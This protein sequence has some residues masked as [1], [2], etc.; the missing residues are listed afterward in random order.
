MGGAGFG[1]GLRNGD[2]VGK[3]VGLRQRKILAWWGIENILSCEGN[4][5]EIEF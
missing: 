5:A 4:L 1:K 2:C 3:L